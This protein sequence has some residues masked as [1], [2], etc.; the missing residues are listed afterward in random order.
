M[1][2][3]KDIKM[4]FRKMRRSGLYYLMIWDLPV[5]NASHRE[6][7]S[8]VMGVVIVLGLLVELVVCMRYLLT[9]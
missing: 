2:V 5:R 1:P 7:G 8:D 3:R 4:I 9:N 6:T